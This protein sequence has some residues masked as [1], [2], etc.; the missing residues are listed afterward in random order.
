MC[1]W[2]ELRRVAFAA[3]RMGVLTGILSIWRW[4]HLVATR[5]WCLLR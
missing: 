5:R 1:A 4:T 3:S 2:R